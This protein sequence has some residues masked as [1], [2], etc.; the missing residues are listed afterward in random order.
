MPTQSTDLLLL[1]NIEDARRTSELPE[2]IQM[3]LMPS[4]RTSNA[5][6]GSSPMPVLAIGGE[7]SFGEHVADAMRAVVDDVQG[8][9]LADYAPKGRV[10]ASCRLGDC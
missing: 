6:S 1:G 9:V 5:S 4:C 10:P 8:V 2:A 7:A 3:R